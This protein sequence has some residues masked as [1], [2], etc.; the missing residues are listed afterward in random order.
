[1]APSFHMRVL[2]A[3]TTSR[4]GSL[5]PH[6]CGLSSS[7]P[8]PWKTDWLLWD[9]PWSLAPGKPQQSRRGNNQ[10]QTIPG[11]EVTKDGSFSDPTLPQSPRE[12]QLA[13]ERSRHDTPLQGPVL[14]RWADEATSEAAPFLSPWKWG[15][16]HP[17]LLALWPFFLPYLYHANPEGLKICAQKWRPC[18][19]RVSHMSG[20]HKFSRKSA[21]DRESCSNPGEEFSR[22]IRK[23]SK[24]ND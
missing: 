18:P 17:L 16:L 21:G 19:L 8:T 14:G 5:A 20:T 12:A 11:M 3:R 13:G 4:I 1:M 24:S 9:W 2:Q 23:E 22:N 10:V 7:L 15:F 6:T